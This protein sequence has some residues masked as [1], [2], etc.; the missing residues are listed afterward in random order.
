MYIQFVCERENQTKNELFLR[1]LVFGSQE[2]P[3]VYCK[4]YE[5]VFVFRI[6]YI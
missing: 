5:L 2:R 4:L 6:A 1:L 3:I